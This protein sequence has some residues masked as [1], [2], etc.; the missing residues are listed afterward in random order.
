MKKNKTHKSQW[1]KLTTS[2]KA[3]ERER[4]RDSNK[5]Q[6]RN[7]TLTAVEATPPRQKPSKSYYFLVETPPPQAPPPLV[8]HFNVCQ[9]SKPRP[10]RPRSCRVF[11]A[12]NPRAVVRPQFC[13]L[14]VRKP[15]PH[16]KVKKNT[17]KDTPEGLPCPSHAQNEITH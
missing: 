13:H 17:I 2:E 7:E 12:R 8:L 15:R 11:R 6:K 14:L 3:N 1:L 4:T 16:R 10:T 5:Q 9:P